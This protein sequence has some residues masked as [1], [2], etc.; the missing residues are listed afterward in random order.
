M[1]VHP[2]SDVHLSPGHNGSKLCK[3]VQT[4]LPE[5]HFSAPPGGSRGFPRPVKIHNVCS[6]LWVFPGVSYQL[7]VP[8]K[9]P[10]G[11]WS[12]VQTASTGSLQRNR[13][14]SL[15]RMPEPLT[16]S[17]R[18]SPATS[19]RKLTMATCIYDL[20][21]FWSLPKAYAPTWGLDYTSTGKPNTLPFGSA[22]SS[23]QQS[24]TT[25]ALVLTPFQSAHPSHTPFCLHSWTR[26]QNTWT[27]HH[28]PAAGHGLRLGGADFHHYL[29][30]VRC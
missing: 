10:R 29:F 14:A 1:N 6:V 23:P 16:L 17:L 11:S 3:A 18:L 19:Q 2:S 26:P 20:W 24:C 22:L 13:A 12:G 30:T 9:P 4:S 5:K 21:L 8:G 27:I 25:P 7:D 28:F 15:L